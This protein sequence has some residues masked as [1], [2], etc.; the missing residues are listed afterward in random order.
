MSEPT[1][2]LKCGAAV[3]SA[4]KHRRWHEALESRLPGLE[5]EVKKRREQGPSGRGVGF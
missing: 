2:C 5:A 1:E 4:A 3:I